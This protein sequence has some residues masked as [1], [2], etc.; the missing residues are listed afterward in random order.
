MCLIGKLGDPVVVQ[1]RGL[2]A[3]E[4]SDG[5]RESEDAVVREKESAKEAQC[6][7]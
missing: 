1:T 4:V 2:D 6:A 5:V 7:Q 3:S